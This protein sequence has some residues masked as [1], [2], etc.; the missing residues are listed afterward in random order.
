MKI[1]TKVQVTLEFT[2][3]TAFSGGATFE[4]V[5]RESQIGAINRFKRIM[6]GAADTRGIQTVGEPKVCIVMTEIDE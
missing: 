1:T 3:H 6:N 2:T 5:V 4:Q